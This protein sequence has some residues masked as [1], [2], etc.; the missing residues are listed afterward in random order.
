MRLSRRSFLLAAVAAKQAMGLSHFEA[1]SGTWVLQQITSAGQLAAVE[2]VLS[3]PAIR[4]LSLRFPWKTIDEDFSLLEA[5]AKAA[6][7]HGISLSIRFMAGRHTPARVFDAGSPFY[8]RGEEKVPVPFLP[9]GSPNAIFEEIYRKFVNRLANWCRENSVPLLHMAWYGQ[10]WAE[11][12][13][14]LDVRQTKGYTFE[15]W[16]RAHVR[17]IDIALE[18]TDDKLSTEFPFSGHGPLTDAAPRF[19][20]HVV[21]NIGPNNP[22]FFCQANGWGPK[23]EWGAPNEATE[24]AFDRVW[25]KPICRGLQMI[26]PQDYDWPTVFKRLYNVKATYCEVYAPSFTLAHRRELTEEIRKFAKSS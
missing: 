4:G 5:G 25:E 14:G 24:A 7:R 11:L 22:K 21:S 18:T 10:D 6:R 1:V 9:D 20:D 15:N 26:Q 12:N 2:P 3:T 13:H 8:L 16:L 23:G 19:A 17:L